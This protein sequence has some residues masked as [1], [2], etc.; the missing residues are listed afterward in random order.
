MCS[1]V[2]HEESGAL[3]GCTY[4]H[5]ASTWYPS[6]YLSWCRTHA[7]PCFN[8]S[9]S[10]PFGVRSNQLYAPMS[11]V[12]PASVARIRVKD[13]AGPIVVEHARAGPFLARE[14]LHSIV[15]VH[16]AFLQLL[17]RHRDLVVVIEVAA[18]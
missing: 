2:Q 12:Q 10:R 4:S 6:S 14:F 8:P 7:I 1:P 16:F 9:S 15:V 11:Y 5:F 17:L 13:V 3:G 18:V